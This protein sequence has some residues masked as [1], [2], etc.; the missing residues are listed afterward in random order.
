M[1]W[2]FLYYTVTG[3][4]ANFVTLFLQPYLQYEF[5]WVV[6]HTVLIFVGSAT[7]YAVQVGSSAYSPHICG[8]C[9]TLRSPGG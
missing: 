3:T 2:H 4:V 8:L 9:H 6:Q 1:I 7:L 5:W